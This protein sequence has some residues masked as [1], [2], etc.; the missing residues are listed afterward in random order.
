[1]KYTLRNVPQELDRKLRARAKRLGKSLNEVTILA[2][3]GALGESL[4]TSRP[5]RDLSD[6]AGAVPQDSR[7]EQAL[8]DQRRIDP[9]IWQ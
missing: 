7:V 1:M 8:E 9:G 6:I 5:R 2:L 3:T 4:E